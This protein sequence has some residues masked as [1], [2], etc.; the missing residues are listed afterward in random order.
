MSA[1]DLHL[2]SLGE[3]WEI[4]DETGRSLG[5]E[6]TREEAFTKALRLAE[7]RGSLVRIIVHGD[8]G[9]VEEVADPSPPPPQ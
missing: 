4:E 1:E 3:H 5:H 8:D 2:L 9:S 6:P 7:E